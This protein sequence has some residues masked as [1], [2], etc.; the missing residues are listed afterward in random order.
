M[1]F[2]E[3]LRSNNEFPIIFIGS[4]ITQRYFRNAPTWDDL[5]KTIW[6]ECSFSKK[7]YAR[8]NE[9][10]DEYGID[11]FAIYTAL[12][13]EI[14]HNYNSDFFDEKVILTNLSPE[15]AHK[16]SIS[17]FKYRIAELFS[18]LEMKE[19]NDHE[20][21][22]FQKMLQKARLIVTTNYDD[23]I[24]KQFDNKIT[25]KVGNKGLFEQSN[26]INELYK[27]HGSIK[28]PNSIVISSK[29]YQDLKRTSAIVNAKIL[30]QLTESPIIF[31]GYSLTDRNIRSLLEDLS[32]N[33]TTSV[34]QA[35]SRIGVVNF[36]PG[37]KDINESIMNIKDVYYTQLSTDN[38]SEIYSSISEINQG[39]TPSEIATF[40][41]MFKQIIDT[42]GKS[43]ELDKVLTSFVEM[44]KLP[45]ELRRKNLVVAFG[46]KRYIYKMPNYVDYVK[47]YFLSNDMPLDIAIKFISE[48]QSNSTLPISK[49]LSQLLEIKDHTLLDRHRNTIN[50][51]LEKFS[52]L[53]SLNIKS[54]SR[55]NLPILKNMNFNNPKKAMSD[56]RV[57]I[58]D[59]FA[60]LGIHI[61]EL[62][63]ETIF[64][65]IKYI[66]ENEQDAII[67]ETDFRK[68]LM[69]YSL[70]YEKRFSKI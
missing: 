23:F 22:L 57:K 47:S 15:Q 19:G 62:E 1:S 34:D 53:S 25:V 2:L 20:L 35:A 21:K 48:S 61:D 69:A 55:K 58:R 5:L 68:L 9:L 7:Y 44:N 10:K 4:G 38:Y 24:E 45:E 17:P 27:I 46:D 12:A 63:K 30:S 16:R 60:Y 26:N 36:T 49:Y 40:Q 67:K 39:I 50:L 14:E 18:N 37:L 59:K 52:S 11:Q 56:N 31:I 33:L 70:K 41:S 32:N 66:L 51:R 29:D 13:D 65:M 42:K 3:K 54:P 64:N 28:D 43:G 6:D 8:F